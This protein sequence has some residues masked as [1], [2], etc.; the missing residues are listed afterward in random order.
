MRHPIRRLALLFTLSSSA[1]LLGACEPQTAQVAVVLPLSG[2]FQAYGE[3]SRK[4]LELALDELNAE[5][6]RFEAQWADSSSDPETAARKLNELFEAKSLVAIGGLTSKEAE[7]MIPVAEERER[8]LLSPSALNS[9]L[10]A[11]ARHFY[12]I[13]PSDHVAGNVMADFL[14]R[15][16]KGMDTVVAIAQDELALEGF[17][18]GFRPTFEANGGTVK[19]VVQADPEGLSDTVSEAI[20]ATPDVVYLAGY[21]TAVGD[22]LKELRRQRFKG[23]I[24]TDQTLASPAAIQQIGK[25]AVGVLLTH[26]VMDAEINEKA[27][28][29]S[30]SFEARYGE[31]PDIFAAEAYDTM[32]VVARALRDRP[33]YPG[34]LQRGLRDDVKDF[35]GVTGTI[36]FNA[37]GS[38]TKYPR[39]Y[40]VAKNLSLQDEG[41]RLEAEEA[42]RQERIRK[43]R[44][45][46]KK[47][48]DGQAAG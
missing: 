34:E 32:M 44:E 13:A 17:E 30:E 39:V 25:D 27:R 35:P 31:K 6:P 28:N 37:T 36:E 14:A 46:L 16:M 15:K 9:R 19:G 2:E 10:A 40:S 42:L 3:S 18:E 38:V 1:F 33:A 43:I 45:K 41:R 26:S 7:A 24:L 22:V 8:I 4:G 20:G 11:E 48:Q 23:K 12:R 29:F 5:A 21:G 47:V